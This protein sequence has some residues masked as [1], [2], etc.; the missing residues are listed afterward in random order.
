M[1]R[2]TFLIVERPGG[3]VTIA[4][5]SRTWLHRVHQG[6]PGHLGSPPSASIARAS[7]PLP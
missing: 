2:L 5:D 4:S 1:K 7:M 6:L 3:A